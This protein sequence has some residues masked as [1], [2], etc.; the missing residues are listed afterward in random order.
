M[1]DS[2][3]EG[4]GAESFFSLHGTHSLFYKV[5]IFPVHNVAVS[6]PT[7][8]NESLTFIHIDLC[9]HSDN[10]LPRSIMVIDL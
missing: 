4:F 5:I 1:T 2:V 10:E 9:E 8:K 6:I 7:Y 3:R